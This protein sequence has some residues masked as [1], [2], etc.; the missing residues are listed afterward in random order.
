MGFRNLSSFLHAKMAE[1]G[2]QLPPTSGE[3]DERPPPPPVSPSI[4]DRMRGLFNRSHSRERRRERNEE[5]RIS[6]VGSETGNDDDGE[7]N[8]GEWTAEE[9]IYRTYT[10]Q[11]PIGSMLINMARD[12]MQLLKRAGIKES[13]VNLKDLCRGFY[14]EKHRHPTVGSL[15]EGS[16]KL[17]ERRMLDRELNSHMMNQ[18]ISP[19]TYFSPVPTLHTATARFE[20]GKHFPSRKEKFSGKPG[21]GMN[22]VEYLAIANGAQAV[23]RL[24]EEEFKE[25][26]LNSV[27]GKAHAHVAS[28]IEQGEDVS[29]IYHMLELHYDSRLSAVDARKFLSSYRIPKSS[30]LAEGVTHIL[31]LATRVSTHVPKGPTRTALYNLEAVQAIQRALPPTSSALAS[32]IYNE[33]SSKLQRGAYASEFTRA[34]NL[35]RASIDKDIHN[36]GYSTGDKQK[37]YWGKN[38]GTKPKGSNGNGKTVNAVSGTVGSAPSP[39][40]TDQGPSNVFTIEGNPKPKGQGFGNGKKNKKQNKNGA[41]KTRHWDTT[42]VSYCSLCGDPNHKASMGCGNMRDSNGKLVT[43][44]PAHSVCSLC[45]SQVSPRLNHPP[46]YCP[47]RAGGPFANSFSNN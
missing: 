18:G 16:A 34:L 8:H 38:V 26:L 25:A 6:I 2:E 47:F 37:G 17:V 13:H 41:S 46:S 43:V 28:W 4:Q 32:N 44:M 29:G 45:P 42:T 21:D 19:P 30:N 14:M 7:S 40:P 20:A 36:N 10:E 31:D 9:E 35:Y 27:T 33:V 12:N 24:S 11:D 22:V 1:G 5:D 3:A 15:V 39:T 23:L